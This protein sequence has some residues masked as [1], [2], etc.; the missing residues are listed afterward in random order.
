MLFRS[1]SVS[2][3][4]LVS[5]LYDFKGNISEE[6]DFKKNDYLKILD[7]NARDG[8]I[9]GYVEGNYQVKGILPKLFVRKVYY[10]NQDH[11]PSYEEVIREK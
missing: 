2:N 7:W 3:E 11:L 5:A 10:E 8:W 9:Y 1:V 6:L 4:D